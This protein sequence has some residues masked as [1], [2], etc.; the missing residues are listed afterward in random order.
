M[1]KVGYTKN[2]GENLHLGKSA[3]ITKKTQLLRD[4]FF[5]MS[6][7]GGGSGAFRKVW[8]YQNFAPP[9]NYRWKLYPPLAIPPS[10]ISKVQCQRQKRIKEWRHQ[11]GYK[12]WVRCV[13][14][15]MANSDVITSL[16]MCRIARELTVVVL[17]KIWAHSAVHVD[18]G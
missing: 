14:F 6:G 1:C 17:C 11:G 18:T 16:C 9:N 3:Q 2:L 13:P 4:W 8:C 5:I 7:G 10:P 12:Q 15:R